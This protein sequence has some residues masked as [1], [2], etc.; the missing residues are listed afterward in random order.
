MYFFTSNQTQSLQNLFLQPQKHVFKGCADKTRFPALRVLHY[1]LNLLLSASL[2]FTVIHSYTQPFVHYSPLNTGTQRLTDGCSPLTFCKA[3]FCGAVGVF[4][5]GMELQAAL[6]PAG[7]LLP[8][9]PAVL[10]KHT[11]TVN[12]AAPTC[13]LQA[14]APYITSVRHSLTNSAQNCKAQWLLYVPQ[15]LRF[16]YTVYLCVFYKPQ[17]MTVIFS[18]YTKITRFL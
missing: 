15:V 16:V 9:V 1:N 14:T 7:D 2:L 17:T 13:G 5:S 12:C 6:D 8:G 18:P 10:Q 3:L 11:I 4:T